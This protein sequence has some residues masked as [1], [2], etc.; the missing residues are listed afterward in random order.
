LLA[1][2]IPRRLATLALSWQPVGMAE[3]DS[4]GF[5]EQTLEALRQ[6]ECADACV[7]NMHR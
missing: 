7:T 5:L 6:K 3:E 2:L 1:C 4:N